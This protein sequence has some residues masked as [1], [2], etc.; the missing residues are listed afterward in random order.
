MPRKGYDYSAALVDQQGKIEVRAK[1]SGQDDNA[2]VDI[3]G[4]QDAQLT[5]GERQTQEVNILNARSSVITLNAQPSTG[6]LVFYKAPEL[7]GQRIIQRSHDEEVDFVVQFKEFGEVIT[8]SAGIALGDQADDPKF[9]ITADG[10]ITDANLIAALRMFKVD[11]NGVI[12]RRVPSSGDDEFYEVERGVADSGK[13][14]DKLMM[15]SSL[16]NPSTLPSTTAGT[17]YNFPYN[18]NTASPAAYPASADDDGVLHLYKRLDLTT[19]AP[20]QALGDASFPNFSATAGQNANFSQVTVNL[21]VSGTVT[22]Q[23]GL[24]TA[25]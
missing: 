14:L 23:Y 16:Q 22:L 11:W 10:E 24:P 9:Q 5:P 8:P 13:N 21:S 2:F 25:A 4:I 15:A 12:I 19:E 6:S 7:S 1:L 17:T 20:V 3:T 18:R